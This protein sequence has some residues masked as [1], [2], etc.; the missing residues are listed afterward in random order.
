MKSTKQ[1]Q[2]RITQAALILALWL[3]AQSAEAILIVEGTV[4]PLAGSFEYEFS[5]SNL[6]PNDYVIV[7][8][9]NA[10][11]ADPLI[12]PTLVA[13]VGFLASYDDGLGFVDFLG[14]T[15]LFAVGTTVSG[16]SFESLSGP[17]TVFTLF[18]ALSVLGDSFSGS[19]TITPAGVPETGSSLP[20]ASLSLIALG[21]ARKTIPTTND[22]PSESA[23]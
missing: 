1:I 19:I 16:F 10:P 17:G 12:D 7:S 22:Q 4:T 2:H 3:S 11:L 14:D 8:I 18:E 21:F 9:L 6:G 23:L 5:I 13:P 15:D 20:L